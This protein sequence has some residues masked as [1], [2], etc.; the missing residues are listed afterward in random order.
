M[1][2]MFPKIE[3]LISHRPPMRF[4]DEV[5]EFC[6]DRGGE[7][8]GFL[9]GVGHVPASLFREDAR[10]PAMTL[11]LMAQAVAAYRG[12]QGHSADIPM[13]P[14]PAFLVSV[15]LLS[16]H[17]DALAADAKLEVEAN[18][19]YEDARSGKFECTVHAEGGM[20]VATA[21]LTVAD[22]KPE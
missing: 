4:L 1:K 12:L 6:D 9:R 3:A 5:K 13:L 8:R 7:T 14:K 17:C 15:P 19:V 22:K 11:E 2:A 18:V 20:L 16:L 21:T 10:R